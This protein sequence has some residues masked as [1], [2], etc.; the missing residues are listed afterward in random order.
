MQPRCTSCMCDRAKQDNN[1]D[2]STRAPVSRSGIS[3]LLS[4][5]EAAAAAALTDSVGGCTHADTHPQT[6]SQ[7]EGD[8][9][10]H[11]S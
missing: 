4:G 9:A 6:H 7:E 8:E 5:N 11:I 3:P 2:S 1:T 10:P